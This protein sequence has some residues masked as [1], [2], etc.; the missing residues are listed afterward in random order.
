[1][2]AFRARSA[3]QLVDKADFVEED[4]DEE[5][6]QQEPLHPPPHRRSKRFAGT[7]SHMLVQVPVYK[8]HYE[9]E[10]FADVKN[11]YNQRKC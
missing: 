4:A 8:R 10:G 1:L 11:K 5:E 2:S 6:E 3:V 9:E 7:P